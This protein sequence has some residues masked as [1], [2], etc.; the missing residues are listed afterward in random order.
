MFC[1]SPERGCPAAVLRLWYESPG[2]PLELCGEKA[3]TDRWQYLSSSNSIR[4]S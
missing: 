1:S 2:P 4:L 3:P